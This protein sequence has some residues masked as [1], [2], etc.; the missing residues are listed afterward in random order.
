[1]VEENWGA[2][3]LLHDLE[4]P[5]HLGPSASLSKKQGQARLPFFTSALGI[6]EVRVEGGEGETAGT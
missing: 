5:E 4:S 3:D 6:H 2:P 1:M